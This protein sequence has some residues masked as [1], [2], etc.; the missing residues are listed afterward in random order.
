M[1]IDFSFN[2]VITNIYG[3]NM[4]RTS[5][6]VIGFLL[7]YI[8]IIPYITSMPLKNKEK[9]NIGYNKELEKR[10]CNASS[11]IRTPG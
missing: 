3:L 11:D 7:Q 10:I 9:K 5:N 8:K 4:I 1:L 2:L 6:N